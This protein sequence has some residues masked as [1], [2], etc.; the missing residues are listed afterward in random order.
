MTTVIRTARLVPVLLAI[1]AL[2]VNGQTATDE[3]RLK[4]AFVFRFSQFVAWPSDS[5][6]G[7]DAFGI[8]VEP[9]SPIL[10]ELRDLATDESIDGRPLV[11][12]EITAQSSIRRCNVLFLTSNSRANRELLTRASAMPILTVGDAPGFLDAGGVI[13]LRTV[14][15]RVRFDVDVRAAEKVGLS[16]SSQLLRLASSVRGVP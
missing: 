14:E 3:L 12:R 4:A 11:I 8:C 5:S 13:Q 6:D 7:R 16:F 15:R 10:P 2:A 9:R 1:T